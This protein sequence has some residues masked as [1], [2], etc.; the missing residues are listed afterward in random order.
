MAPHVA[1]QDLHPRLLVKSLESAEH[2]FTDGIEPRGPGHRRSARRCSRADY[3]P[4]RRQL[5]VIIPEFL[6]TLLLETGQTVPLVDGKDVAI[7]VER[8][9]HEPCKFLLS[10]QRTSWS[11]RSAP[12][13]MAFEPSQ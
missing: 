7:A 6:A 3:A 8:L 9:C 2:E 13:L 11:L 1:V 10:D 5:V 12:S 4:G